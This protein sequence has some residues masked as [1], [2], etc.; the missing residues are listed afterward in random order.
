MRIAPPAPNRVNLN[1]L[2]SLAFTFPG[3]D[4]SLQTGHAIYAEPVDR[5]DPLGPI[6]QIGDD[7][8]GFSCVDDV[9]RVALIYLEQFEKT[10]QPQWADKATQAV[11]FCLNQ[12]DGEGRFF[13]FVEKDGKINRDGPTSKPGLN[14]WSARAFWALS[15]AQRVLDDPALVQQVQASRQ[16]TLARLEEAHSQNQAPP[17]L[18]SAYAET[19]IRPGGLVDHS[20]S[21]TSLFALGLLENLDE[22]SLPLLADYC[23]S[24]QKLAVSPEHPMLGDLHL[25][26]LSD[27]NTV[28]LYGNHQVQALALAGARLGRSDWVD[29]ARREA[30]VY[31]RM[32]ASHQLPFAYSPAPEP[33]P[34]IAY[35]AQTTMANLQAVYRATGE[36]KYSDLAG[37]FGTWFSGANVAGKPVYHPPSG[38]AF[39]GVDPHG[40][41]T[42]SGAES[43][44]EAQLAM[45]VMQDSPGQRWLGFGQI[46]DFQ[47]ETVSCGTDFQVIAGQPQ[48]NPRVLNG[49]AQRPNWELDSED[50]LGLASQ[51]GILVWKSAGGPLS[52]DPDGPGPLPAY[53][54]TPQSEQWQT[55]AL[56]D[57][58]NLHIGGPITVDSLLEKPHQLQRSWSDG[59]SQV[60]LRVDP[61]GWRIG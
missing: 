49:G 59:Q 39:D 42:N 17:E 48:V 13:N 60:E 23:D 47:G 26:S 1:N 54:V 37:L 24:M 10:R 51:N 41:S 21:I 32:L 19:G 14:W 25:N 8:E 4:G 2:D 45:S 43:N 52:V 15:R 33:S 35:A 6:Q 38:R 57:G 46:L 34:Q 7:D 31:P 9:A 61:S 22:R 18:A 27:R 50:R 40:V 56:P 3:Q 5:L 12:E 55:T 58:Q 11:R 53:Q 20:G 28:H 30:D 29:S 16:R 36:E 44:V